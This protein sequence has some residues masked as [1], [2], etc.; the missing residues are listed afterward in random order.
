LEK[1]AFKPMT[2]ALTP[3]T[4][5]APA[6]GSVSAY[7][8]WANSIPLL[9]AEEEYQLAKRLRDHNDIEAAKQLILPHIRYVARIARDFMGYGLAFSDLVQE[10]S[11]G[12]MKAVK[13]FDPDMGVRLASYA[14]HWIKS[15]MHE[16]VIKNWRI[17]K[18]A[19]TKAQRKLFFNLRKQKKRLGWHTEAEIQAVAEDLNVSVHDVRTM[20]MRMT[21]Y[22]EA[23]DAPDDADENNG[24]APTHYLEHKDADPAL[25]VMQNDNRQQQR[26]QLHQALAQ[27]DARSREILTARWLSETKAT[28]QSL[29]NTYQVSIERIRQIEKAAMTKV[30]T[31]LQ[32]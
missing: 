20:E 28:L 25:Q 18:I 9:T 17:V 3:Y 32:A 8:N 21:Q 30:K 10:G 31:Q 1:V 4:F 22:D 6:V 15:E 13:R 16:F 23:F 29:A 24:W 19:T 26:T 27:L 12:L 2:Q 5:S 14:V 11:I 7:L